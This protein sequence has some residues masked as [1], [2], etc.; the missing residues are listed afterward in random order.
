MGDIKTQELDAVLMCSSSSIPELFSGDAGLPAV[1]GG[2]RA[3]NLGAALCAART[4]NA[5]R[6]MSD[7][8]MVW[9]V[10]SRYYVV[11]APGYYTSGDMVYPLGDRDGYPTR[12]AAMGARRGRRDRVVIKVDADVCSPPWQGVDLD[13]MDRVS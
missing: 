11:P 2:A 8:P 4:I 6:E 12:D 5:V 7:R 1:V 10:V 13:R 3:G 9:I